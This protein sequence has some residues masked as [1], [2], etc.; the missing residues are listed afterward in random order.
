MN[1]KQEVN[2]HVTNLVNKFHDL[3]DQYGDFRVTEEFDDELGVIVNVEKLNIKNFY[4]GVDITYQQKEG[5]KF[6]VLFKSY[7]DCD[8]L[9]PLQEKMS[10][11]PSGEFS[12]REAAIIL[13]NLIKAQEEISEQLIKLYKQI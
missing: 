1:T 11:S 4:W 3:Y 5:K 9:K 13:N 7:D 12:Y 8:C 6:T 10:S 2:Q